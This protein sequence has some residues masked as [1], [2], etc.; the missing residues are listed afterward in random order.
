MRVARWLTGLLYQLS[1]F[2]TRSWEVHFHPRQE[3]LVKTLAS[4]E[5]VTPSRVNEF[6]DVFPQSRHFSRRKRSSGALEPTP[7][8]THYRISAYGQLF[9]LNLSAD[10]AFLA[11]GYTEVH[12]GTSARE[13]PRRSATAPD[14]RHCFYR[15]QVNARED[16][17]AVFSLCGGLMGTFKAHD[18][19]YFLEPIMRADGDEQEDD[20]NKPHLI[21]RQE[22]K[23]NSF[24]QP[25]R[26]CA[27]SENQIRKTTLHLHNYGSMNEDPNVKKE[28][29]FGYPSK[30]RSLEDERSQ[31]HSRNK[32][33]LSYPRYVEVMVTTDAKMVRHHGQNLQHYV[34]TLMSIV[35]AIYKDSSIGNLIN[36]V[37]VK[38]IIIHNEQEGP[39]ISF[40][41]ATTL[42][43][44]CLWQQTQ[45]VLDDSHP[46]HHD[47]AVLITR[48]DICGAKEKCDT[49]GL[50]ELGTLCDPLRSC[51]I[52]EENGL[53]AAFTVAHE[54]GHVFN[55]PHDD[56]FKCKE[57][58]IKHQYHVM[59][60]TLNYH[61]SPWTW[62]KC[63]Q[64]YITEFLDTGHGE[65]L[66]DKPNGRVYDLSSQLPG[67][68]YD[69]NK[70]CELM[71]GPGSQECPYLKQCRRLW[72]TSAEGAHR[73]CRTQH[74]PLADGTNCGPGMVGFLQGIATMGCV[75]INKWRLVL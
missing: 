48:E 54:L 71:F 35:A 7:F 38:L 36:I 1:L 3:A 24:L 57:A 34:L 52:S 16:H 49:L 20:H 14:L 45:N 41:A 61:T 29:V 33:F 37:I 67:L 75:Y 50:A 26:P 59:A 64:K 73:G 11:A 39:V 55:V 69:V 43:N 22:L 21:Y 31:L 9:Q 30:N 18:G 40:N 74:M 72:C 44:F 5:V 17:T 63:S 53:S 23:R 12:L 10:A 58:G 19:E 56:S 62:S 32:R 60:P 27:V 68:M 6:G 25:H 70:Q 13:A 2:L 47:T 4:Y 15:G 66:L 28:M 42:R 46:S 65:C 51:S 8:R